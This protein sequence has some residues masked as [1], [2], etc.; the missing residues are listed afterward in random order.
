LEADQFDESIG[1]R[2]D[3]TDQT[4]VTIDPADARDFDDAI[5]LDRMENGHWRLGVH[6]A[7]VSHF[8][9][10][11]T[12]LDQEARQRATSVYLPDRVIPMLPEIISNGLASLQPGRVRYTQSVFIEMTAEGARVDVQLHQAAISSKHRFTYEEVDQ[13]L[14]DPK[15]WRTRLDR[16]VCSLVERM[17]KLAMMLRKRRLERG[18]IELELPEI[19]IEFD[20][21]GRVSGARKVEHTESHQ[22]IEEFMLAANEAV[23]EF[24]NDR[25]V[26][27]L[28][29]IHE[30]PDPRKLH[31]LGQFVRELG[32]AC[33]NPESRFEI[34]RIVQ[35]V[36]GQPEEFAVNFAV[37][38]AMQKAVH[39]PVE[40]GHYA[41]NSEHYCHFTS[42][43]RRY[44]D[45]VIHRLL[46]AVTHHQRP[47]DALPKLLT[48]GDHC[49]ERE[50]RAEDAE[51]ELVKLK[52]LSYLSRRI[53]QRLPAVIVNVEKYGLFAQGTQLPAEGLIAVESLLDD[54][55]FYDADTHTLCGH[56]AGNQFRLGDLIEVEIGHVD[57]DRR[58]L[59]FRYV[60][61]L[62]HRQVQ[63]DAAKSRQPARGKG[64]KGPGRRGRGKRR[65]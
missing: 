44:P 26:N 18:A 30:P 29:R 21:Q 5:S 9:R 14:A 2:L 41:L 20:A 37:L 24:L 54:H 22:I 49:S 11:G 35:A 4:V 61:H 19:K 52:L 55:Y 60:K 62:S 33:E 42:P 3:L 32:I 1:Q 59:D 43:I 53:G 58:E 47:D 15:P 27:L 16:S 39:S 45:L 6:I 10:P 7:D 65:R 51:R 36:R 48:L 8:V 40:E 57:L 28:R 25:R 50:R 17:H 56:R 64:D 34:K 46:H 38:K 63:R 13:Y 23:A 31:S 12:P